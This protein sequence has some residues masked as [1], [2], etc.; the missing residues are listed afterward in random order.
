MIREAS[1]ED[2]DAIYDVETRCFSSD[3][4][5]RRS[6]TY[7]IK[8][9]ASHLLVYTHYRKIAGYVLTLCP[10]RSKFARHYSLAILPEYRNRGVGRKLLNSAEK[11]CKGL[12]DGFKLEIRKDNV[13]AEKLYEDMGYKVSGLKKNY[14]E[15]GEDAI[16]MVKIA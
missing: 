12:Y 3:I 15:D 9:P 2:L 6:L 10:K 16:E 7:M 8:N 11:K 4:I 1:M 14:Y 5:S 13:I